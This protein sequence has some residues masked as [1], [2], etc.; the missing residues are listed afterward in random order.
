LSRRFKSTKAELS[1]D[2]GSEK[3]IIRW[4]SGGHN[5]C[6]VAFG[7]DGLLYF[8]TGDAANPDAAKSPD[9]QVTP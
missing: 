5:G 2:A 3:V 7:N 1:I 4:L 8:S 9:A 6:T